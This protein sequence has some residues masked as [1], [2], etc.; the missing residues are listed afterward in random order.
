MMILNPS[1]EKIA[2][3]LNADFP[4]ANEIKINSDLTLTRTAAG[5]FSAK[6]YPLGDLPI[7]DLI[8]VSVFLAERGR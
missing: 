4:D 5:G 8:K 2:E 7:D 1:P 3:K 6:G